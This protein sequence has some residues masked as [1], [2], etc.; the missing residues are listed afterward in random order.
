MLARTFLTLC[1]SLSFALSSVAL[2]LLNLTCAVYL[3]LSQDSSLRLRSTP[4]TFIVLGCSRGEN[5]SF[6]LDEYVPYVES[7]A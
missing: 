1:S 2:L 3:E 4:E 5:K 6:K 7:V